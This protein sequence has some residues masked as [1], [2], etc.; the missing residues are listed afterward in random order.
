MLKVLIIDD[1]EKVC[2]L[3]QW[4]IDWESVSYTHLRQGASAPSSAWKMTHSDF[5]RLS[6]VPGLRYG[7]S[8][9]PG[10]QSRSHRAPD[11][12]PVSYTHLVCRQKDPEHAQPG[13]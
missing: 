2:R 13:K 10:E 5:R 4:L 3:I 11:V 6:R 12:S 9:M 7:L 8:Y 1:E